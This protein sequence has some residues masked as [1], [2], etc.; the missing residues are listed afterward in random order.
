M[1]HVLLWRRTHSAR[2][3]QDARHY[4]SCVVL[5]LDLDN[6]RQEPESISATR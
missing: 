1:V 2:C 3:S 4:F 6:S 5:D